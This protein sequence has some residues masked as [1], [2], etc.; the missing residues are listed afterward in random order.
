LTTGVEV[1]GPQHQ[2]KEKAR[3][4]S[5]DESG[6]GDKLQMDLYVGAPSTATSSRLAR[7]VFTTSRLLEFCSEKELV[8]QTGHSIEQWPLV[9]LKELMDNALD[10]CEEADIAPVIQ[11]NLRSAPDGSAAISLA[12]N[13]PGIRPETVK[14][15]LDFGVRVS[16][17]EAYVG[18]TRGAQGN[19]FQT[20]MAMPFVVSG[21]IVGTTTI[22]ARGVRHRIGFTVDQ[23]RREPK[24]EHKQEL[25]DTGSGTTVTVHWPLSPRSQLAE[26]KSRF[27]QIAD[28][29]TWLNPHLSLNVLW[30]GHSLAVAATDTEWRKWCPCEP[31]SA[32]WYDYG[33][34]ERLIAAY[35]AADLDQRRN[36]TVREFI[37][38][39]RG[40][41]GSA[42]QKAVL[43]QTGMTR[44][45]LADLFHG[46]HADCAAIINLLEAMKAATSPVKPHNL[47]LIGKDHLAAK[48]VQAGC[49]PK[50]FEYRKTLRADDGIPTV[51]EV[52]FGY[53]QKGD[54]RRI[55]TGAN[56][57]VGINDP[58]KKLGSQGQSLDGVLTSLRAGPNEP[59][60]TVVHLACPRI[61]YTDRGKG[62]LVLIGET[63]GDEAGDE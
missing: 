37:S 6:Q 13:G 32:H 44:T 12:D 59:I 54:H 55:I 8:L 52:A 25:A 28:D 22:E 26:A 3:P 30:D 45:A 31:T 16:S 14:A 11:I 15:L 42:K 24:I 9:V 46:G 35:V 56:W 1:N 10:A 39:F 33:R 51:I 62:S 27:L 58:F 41:T 49:D 29:Y 40:L 2:T 50:S 7:Q 34:F 18:P 60:T 19:A 17:R 38:E 63:N 5:Q 20:L 21:G 57:S 4:S 47:G 61:A 43:N 23:L 53:C 36:R 48:L